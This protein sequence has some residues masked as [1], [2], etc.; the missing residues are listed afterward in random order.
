M[1][2]LLVSLTVAALLVMGHPFTAWP[3]DVLGS[4]VFVERE[5]PRILVSLSSTG[6]LT[7][8]P[9]MTVQECAEIAAMLAS[10]PA[11]FLTESHRAVIAHN[12]GDKR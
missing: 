11:I 4:I 10:N 12:C 7:V 1:K 3:D 9:D 6:V 2:R 8:A 5:A